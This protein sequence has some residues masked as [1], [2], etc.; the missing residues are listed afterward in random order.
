ME[1]IGKNIY[2]C[3]VFITKLV[4]NPNVQNERLKAICKNR[5]IR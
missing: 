5:M 1:N 3:K 4:D 2:T